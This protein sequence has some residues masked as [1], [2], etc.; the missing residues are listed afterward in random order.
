MA[1]Y[2]ITH[3]VVE[4]L[5]E[6]EDSPVDLEAG[7]V[8]RLRPGAFALGVANDWWF[9]DALEVGKRYSVSGVNF[10]RTGF[11][12]FTDP[13]GSRHNSH[14]PSCVFEVVERPQGKGK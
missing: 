3:N 4:L 13:D 12:E 2:T 14:Y 5:A 7:Y 8:V 10:D 11:I 9:G 1:S 6:F